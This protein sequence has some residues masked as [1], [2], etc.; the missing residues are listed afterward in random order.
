LQLVADRYLVNTDA[1]Q[2]GGQ[3]TIVKAIDGRDNG[4]PVALKFISRRDADETQRAF[5]RREV[6][7]LHRLD[8][9]N[10]VSLRDAGEDELRDAPRVAVAAGGGSVYSRRLLC[11]W[12]TGPLADRVDDVAA[13]VHRPAPT[14]T[15]WVPGRD[16]RG[17]ELPLRVGGV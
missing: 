4:A 7:A 3:G 12:L 15:A 6:E 5:F 14:P 10:I 8:H 2:V 17:D 13:R 16:E 11:R 1:E 9:P